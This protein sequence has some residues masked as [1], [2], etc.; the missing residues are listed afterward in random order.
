MK[1]GRE[2]VADQ[3]LEM[4][5]KILALAADFD[6]IERAAGDGLTDPRVADL[7]DCVRELLSDRPGRAERV[8]MRLSD[9]TPPPAK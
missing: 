9:L 2:I 6:R 8:Q 3:F 4:R 7:R 5:G 1:T